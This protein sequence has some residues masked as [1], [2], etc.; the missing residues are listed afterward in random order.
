MR[1]FCF[2]S[3]VTTS[4]SNSFWLSS[5]EI[6]AR[7]HLSR[8]KFNCSRLSSYRDLKQN[9]GK[10]PRR[11]IV[12]GDDDRDLEWEI[13]GSN[14][15]GYLAARSARG[16]TFLEVLIIA[17]DYLSIVVWRKLWKLVLVVKFNCS[18]TTK[19]RAWLISMTKR[20]ASATVFHSVPPILEQHQ[21]QWSQR[22]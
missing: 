14:S 18:T 3:T 6:C 2:S 5:C 12:G 20:Q 22:Q 1:V 9:R 17:C 16:N 21:Q 15:F 7:E 19:R 11:R 13:S 10:R 4:A 8:R